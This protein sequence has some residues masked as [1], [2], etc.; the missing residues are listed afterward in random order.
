MISTL[1]NFCNL[2][3]SEVE[4]LAELDTGLESTVTFQFMLC[5]KS[6]GTG[7]SKQTAGIYIDFTWQQH[8]I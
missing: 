8:K 4:A 1:E 5:G 7:H 2:R 6:S 3:I